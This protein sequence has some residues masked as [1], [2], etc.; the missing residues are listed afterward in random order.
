MTVLELTYA[1]T[2]SH[3]DD[4][5][6]SCGQAV[7]SV[8]QVGAVAHGRDDEDDQGD[9]HQPDVLGRVVHQPRQEPGV[10]EVVVLDEGNGGGGGAH[11]GPRAIRREFLD[12]DVRVP[13]HGCAQNHA[14]PHLS[15]DLEATGQSFLVLL[16]HLDV[17]VN[18]PDGSKPHGAQDHELGVH[19]GQ[20]REQQ[21][22]DED[23][24]ED[25]ESAHGGGA[26][27]V[28]LAFKPQVPHDFAHLLQLESLNDPLAKQDAHQEARQQAHPGPEGHEIEQT[29]ARQVVEFA[30]GGEE[31]VQHGVRSWG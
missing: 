17:V 25:D 24:P 11:G 15:N 16:E 23:G 12:R 2:A 14:H 10:V 29:Q 3:A 21:G 26:L 6:R 31:V 8:G 18:E 1:R 9:E 20:V 22:R 7:D 4:G 30:E 27:L 5:A 13:H 19:V 28:H